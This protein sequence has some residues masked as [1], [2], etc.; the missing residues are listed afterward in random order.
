MGLEVVN[1]IVGM[2]SGS[3]R[4][5]AVTGVHFVYL[6]LKQIGTADVYSSPSSG[7]SASSNFLLKTVDNVSDSG[8][9]IFLSIMF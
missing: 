6:S 7:P 2:H 5:S 3:R 4:K 1:T 8:V 9:L